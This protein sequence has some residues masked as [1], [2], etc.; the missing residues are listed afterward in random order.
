MTFWDQ[1]A[2]S[3]RARKGEFTGT[4]GNEDA[5]NKRL[6][7]GRSVNI[8]NPTSKR[9]YIKGA[10]GR[11]P[12]GQ[13]DNKHYVEG[14]NTAAG[15]IDIGDTTSQYKKGDKAQVAELASTAIKNARYDPD[16][17]SLNITFQGGD[18][19]YKYAADIDDVKEFI[20]ADSKG[21][22]IASWNRNGDDPHTHPSFM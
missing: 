11:R 18:K 13:F 9:T 8:S 1:I 10:Q 20:D 21:R 19:E 17:N 4:S 14:Y 22:L 3:L 6:D 7:K 5:I 2:N 12:N 16:D 15:N